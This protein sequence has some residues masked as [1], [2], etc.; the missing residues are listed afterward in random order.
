MLTKQDIAQINEMVDDGWSLIGPF[1]NFTTGWRM[2]NGKP[3]HGGETVKIN[4]AV[5]KQ[6][7]ARMQPLEGFRLEYMGWKK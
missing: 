2:Q 5:A 4:A 7:A 3:G 6:V 1:Y